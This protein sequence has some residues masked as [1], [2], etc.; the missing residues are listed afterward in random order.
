[1]FGIVALL[2]GLVE[3]LS[4]YD[5]DDLSRRRLRQVVNAPDHRFGWSQRALLTARPRR[6]VR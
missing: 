1:M 4:G 5:E 2:V 3:Q 6:R